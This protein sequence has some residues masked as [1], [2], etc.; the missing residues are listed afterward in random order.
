[1]RIKIK[2]TK[3]KGTKIKRYFIVER[4]QYGLLTVKSYIL[5]NMENNDNASRFYNKMIKKGRRND[6]I[7]EQPIGFFYLHKGAFG[8]II[9]ENGYYYFI[10]F[11][12]YVV[13]PKRIPIYTTNLTCPE[14]IKKNEL[15]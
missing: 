1:M 4:L 14:I 10:E 5:R 13:D 12:D 9:P 6:I 8:G 11:I 7:K 2:K 15:K 3:I